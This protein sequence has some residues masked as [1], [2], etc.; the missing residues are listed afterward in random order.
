MKYLYFLLFA[1]SISFFSVGQDTTI[2]QTF[3]L[4]STVREGVFSFPDDPGTTY[5]KI[6]MQY[7]MRCHD[8]AIGNGN[9]GC[10]EWD[11]HCNTVVTD[12]SLTDSVWATHPDH[13][14]TGSSSNPYFYITSPTFNYLLYTQHEVL[15][16]SIITEDSVLIGTGLNDVDIPFS[17]AENIG[18]TQVL[19]LASEL[20]NSGLNQGEITGLRHFVENT[21]S[22]VE[23][24]KIKMKHTDKTY[25]DELAPEIDGFTEVYFLN[26]LIGN[27]DKHSFNFYNPFDWNGSDNLLV[28]YSFTQNNPGTSTYILGETTPELYSI[29][30]T[31]PDGFANFNQGEYISVPAEAFN[32]IS[33]VITLA[34]WQYGNPELQPFNSYIF[35]GGD[36]GNNRVINSHLPWGNS[37]VYWDA[38]NSGTNAYDRIDKE[39]NFGDFAGQWNYWAFTKN[40]T[41]GEMKIYL[42]GSLWHSGTDKFK[43]MEGITSFNI[44]GNKSSGQYAGYINDFAVWNAELDEQSIKDWMFKSI[45]NSHPYWSDLLFYYKL[46][47]ANNGIVE[48]FSDN[49]YDGT[50]VGQPL[51]INF[52]GHQLLKDF[53]PYYERPN[54]EF[55]QGS[56]TQN[57]LETDYLDSLQRPYNAVYSYYVLNNDL[58]ANDTNIYWEAGY[59]PVNDESGVLI[60]SIYITAEDSIEIE[61]LEYYQKWPSRFELVS[62]IT[63]YGNGLDLGQEGVMWEFDVSDF[64]P[65]L[66]GD[67]YISIEGVGRWS[68]EYD[69]RFLFIEGTPFRDVI[70]IHSI[71]PIANPNQLWYGV[72]P[73]AIINDEKFEPREFYFPAEV[74]SAKIKSAITGHGQTGEFSPKWHYMDIDGGDWEFNYKVWKECSTV[75]VYPQG[76]T[77]PFDRAGWCPGDPTNVYEFDIT[78]YITPGQSHVIDYGLLAQN[79]FSNADYRISNQIVLYGGPN[80]DFDLDLIGV[81][82]PNREIAAHMRFNPACMEPTVL[83]R[84]TGTTTIV[85][86]KF[87]YFVEGGDVMTHFWTGNLGFLD[88]T[89]V[90]LPINDYTFWL[91]S[92]NKFYV[93]ILQV[94]GITDENPNNNHYEADFDMTDIFDISEEMELHCLTNNYGYQN[95][96]YL[97]DSEGN[98][99]VENSDMENNTLYTDVLSL[100]PGC[101]TLHIDDSADDGLYYWYNTG[102]GAGYLRL[103]NSAG[104]I[105]E[106]LEPEF[107]RWAEYEFAVWDISGTSEVKENR[108]TSV[109][110][111]PASNI[112]NIDLQGF[113]NSRVK[114]ELFDVNDKLLLSKSLQITE[115]KHHEELM[116]GAIKPGLYLLNVNDGNKTRTFKVVKK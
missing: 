87:E 66:K 76:G 64:A 63:P 93:D 108:V 16:T 60:D 99:I 85:S 27:S 111:N 82:N 59:M 58:I 75:P 79:P 109:Y 70:G 45:N 41:S 61:T 48:D 107:G 86:V 105:L 40:A 35:E 30:T 1:I 10:Y 83:F 19:Y 5:Q 50:V 43:T 15:Y 25:L 28:E 8:A 44:A 3:T 80:Y 102:Q 13:V 69:I 53:T 46:D 36:A 55:V 100:S 113:G 65:V 92:E 2:V 72:G 74:S 78:P 14:I 17:T 38:G 23:F 18:K 4:D 42:N 31:T 106:N 32:D 7:R 96:Y 114:F 54:T 57:I 68:E 26:T 9:I 37:R 110:P 115:N 81:V 52:K 67:K 29:H 88:S 95:S 103:K 89:Y 62:F 56:Y 6:I 20:S 24:L 12:S 116:V 49:A 22:E 73:A 34:F 97:M 112:I 98:I 47:E 71:W 101:Y 11:Y 90:N 21:G 39:A 91:G 51:F 77:W 84:N 104:Y 94:N 33:D